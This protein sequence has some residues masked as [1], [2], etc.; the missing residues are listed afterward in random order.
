[1]T[2][3]LSIAVIAVL[4]CLVTAGCSKSNQNKSATAVPNVGLSATEILEAPDVDQRPPE[5]GKRPGA[6][7]SVL[8]AIATEPFS[9]E[10]AAAE[11]E[12]VNATNWARRVVGARELI[13]ESSLD[14]Y[15]RDHAARMAANGKIYHS[16]IA[17]LLGVF[18]FVGENVGD[19]PSVGSIQLA[20]YASP[21]HFRN[22]THETFEYFGVGVFLDSAGRVWTVQEYAA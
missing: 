14:A 19:G 10:S 13:R 16:S 5:G 3:K 17:D 7:T 15:A 9:A 22:L 12:F 6:D 4:L 20:Y 18:W 1:M 21:G 11:I 8:S 2:K